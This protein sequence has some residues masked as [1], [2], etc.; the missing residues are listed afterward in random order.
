MIF[1]GNE[2]LFGVLRL[3]ENENTQ[4]DDAAG[5]L[6]I[7]NVQSAWLR[8]AGSSS[9]RVYETLLEK[10]ENASIVLKLPSQIC[11]DLQLTDTGKISVDVQFQL[12]RQ[13]LC[14]WHAAIDRLGAIHRRLLFPEPNATHV[15]QE[16]TLLC[17]VI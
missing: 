4:P 7:R 11:L 16:V 2:E 9:Q 10:V 15:T 17:L 8:L 12:N 6:L 14:E 3:Q 13:P 5:R 1:A